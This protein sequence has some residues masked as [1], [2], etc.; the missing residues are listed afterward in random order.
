MKLHT[1][2]KCTDQSQNKQQLKHKI[3][4]IHVHQH[5]KK[6]TKYAIQKRRANAQTI[7]DQIG[8]KDS[9]DMAQGHQNWFESVKLDKDYQHAD[10]K[11]SDLIKQHP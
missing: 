11:R 3:K 5:L 8:K 6:L 1:Y 7:P 9:C 2:C 10:F 4:C